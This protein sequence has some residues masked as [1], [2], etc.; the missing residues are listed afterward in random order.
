MSGEWFQVGVGVMIKTGLGVNLFSVHW[1]RLLPFFITFPYGGGI[2]KYCFLK[3]EVGIFVYEGCIY[4]FLKC[5]VGISFLFL[6]GAD[7]CLC[8]GLDGYIKVRFYWIYLCI[9]L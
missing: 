3:C 5:A 9:I 6:H 7:N 8:I 2:Y 4:K 1:A